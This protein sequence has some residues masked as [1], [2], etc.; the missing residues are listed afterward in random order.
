VEPMK[1]TLYS[2]QRGQSGRVK[3]LEPKGYNDWL[4]GLSFSPDGRYL[5]FC[6]NRP[7]RP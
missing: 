1:R 7:D 3:R 5:L 4:G 6:G 2:F